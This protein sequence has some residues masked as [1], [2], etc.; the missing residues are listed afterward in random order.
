M[1][2]LGNWLFKHRN[3]L[4]P[5]AFLLVFL[6]GPRFFS[7]QLVATIVGA[8]IAFS[9]QLVRVVTIGLKYI[10]RGGRDRRVYAQDL[11]VDGLY[12]HCRNPMY[13]GNLL[14]LLGVAIASN[15][16][17]CVLLALPLFGFVYAAIVA[18]E[19]QYLHGKFGELFDAYVRDVPRWAPK[20]D[21]LASTLRACQFRWRRVLAK[22]YGTPF[23]WI[24]GICLIGIWN[25]WRDGHFHTQ[26]HVAE[27]LASA[28]L[29]A[30]LVWGLIRVLKKRRVLVAD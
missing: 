26:L 9:G 20:L 5:I 19:E 2:A 16:W 17:T 14:I 15:S 7:E 3:A 10:V 1:I 25:L 6:P 11:V 22:E 29:V 28:T 8:S 24:S 18:A 30:T 13:A 23:A 21:G 12:S 27:A 4:F